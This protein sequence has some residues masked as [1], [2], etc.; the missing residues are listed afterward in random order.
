MQ[1]KVEMRPYLCVI[2][3]FLKN[4][5]L[6]RLIQR[7]KRWQLPSAEIMPSTLPES[8]ILPSR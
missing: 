1:I 8:A 4:F 3:T 6:E 7:S 2:Q 5:A